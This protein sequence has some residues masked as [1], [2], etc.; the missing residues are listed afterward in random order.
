MKSVSTEA[1]VVMSLPIIQI[2]NC[3]GKIS[4]ID[5][6]DGSCD[7]VGKKTSERTS[8]EQNTGAHPSLS[9]IKRAA[10]L[11]GSNI[12]SSYDRC[13]FADKNEK[14]PIQDTPSGMASESNLFP[15][16]LKDIKDEH[17]PRVAAKPIVISRLAITRND[18]QDGSYER[19]CNKLN[20]QKISSRRH[21]WIW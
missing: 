13:Y 15:N 14:L 2:S 8:N 16:S 21:S 5:A 20:A 12:P 10:N 6:R 7:I 9:D 18:L 1:A 19:D 11:C 3:G 4:R 17:K